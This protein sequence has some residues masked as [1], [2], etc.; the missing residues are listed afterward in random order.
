MKHEEDKPFIKIIDILA[1]NLI[2]LLFSLPVITIG[3]S[4]SAAHY[5]I[6]KIVA[7][8]EVHPFKMFIKG[9]KDDFKQGLI[10][11]LFSVISLGIVVAAWY[12]IIAN[13]EFNIIFLIIAFFLTS[14][15]LITNIF[16]Y[17]FIARYENTFSNMVKNVILREVQ[18]YKRASILFFSTIV[19]ILI[20]LLLFRLSIVAGI[21]GLFFWPGMIFYT[22]CF[23]MK[24]VFRQIEE[25]Q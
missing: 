1:V 14:T 7:N 15:I 18:F 13:D 25:N 4:T 6:I 19:E 16:M 10:M 20:L 9:F 22:V 2:W 17:S 23:G 21:I 5:V 12:Y 8:K 11:T 24:E 3:A